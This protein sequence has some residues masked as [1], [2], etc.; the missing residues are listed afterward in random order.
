M[1]KTVRFLK[2]TLYIIEFAVYNKTNF[3]LE[4]KP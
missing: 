1:A 2:L 4:D 3:Y